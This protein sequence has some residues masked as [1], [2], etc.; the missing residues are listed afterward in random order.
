MYGWQNHHIVTKSTFRLNVPRTLRSL[1]LVRRDAA[2]NLLLLPTDENVAAFL[3]VSKHLGPTLKSYQGGQDNYMLALENTNDFRNITRSSASLGRVFA[4]FVNYLYNSEQALLNGTLHASPNKLID[5]TKNNDLIN[6]SNDIFNTDA[7]KKITSYFSQLEP[8]EEFPGFTPASQIPNLPGFMA[9][10][11]DPQV[12]S[13]PFATPLPALP[14]FTGTPFAMPMLETFPAATPAGPTVLAQNPNTVSGT[15]SG[16]L[17]NFP[18]PTWENIKVATAIFGAGAAAIYFILNPDEAVEAGFAGF[19]IWK[20][21]SAAGAGEAINRGTGSFGDPLLGVNGGYQP[22]MMGADPASVPQLQYDPSGPALPYMLGVNQS[23]SYYDN[24]AFGNMTGPTAP[25]AGIAGEAGASFNGMMYTQPIVDTSPGAGTFGYTLDGMT[26][27]DSTASYFNN[28]GWM[29]APTFG[30]DFSSFGFGNFGFAPIVLDLDGDGV[31]I[32]PLTASNQY[33]DMAGDGYQHRTAWADRGDG[34][35]VLDTQGDGKI[36]ERNEV[37]F[38]DWD[39]SATSDMQ[40]LR[41]IFDTNKNGKLDAGDAKF[42]AFKI[43]VTNADGTTSLKTLAQ[44]GIAS[45]DLTADK[46][47]RVLEDGSSIDGQTTFTRTNGSTGTAAT[48]SFAAEADGGVLKS[49]TTRGSDGSTTIDN[50]VYDAAGHLASETKLLSV[51]FHQTQQVSFDDDGDGVIDDVRTTSHV[52]NSDG[53][54]TDTASD[55]IG[56]ILL[57]KTVTTTSADGRTVTLLRDTDGDGANDQKEVDTTAADGSASVALNDLNE[58]GSTIR[59][60]LRTVSVG[61]QTATTKTDLDGA[62]GYDLIVTD[63]TVVNNDTSRTQTVSETNKDGSLRDRTI[64]TTSADGLTQRQSVDADGDTKIDLFHNTDIVRNGDGSITTTVIEKNGNGSRR[65]VTTTQISGDGLTRNTNYDINGDGVVDAT[66]KETTVVGTTGSRTLYISD[67]SATGTLLDKTV[68]LKEADGISRMT[69]IDADGNGK[70]DSVDQISVDSGVVTEILSNYRPDGTKLKN[71]TVT[72]TSADGLRKTTQYYLDGRYAPGAKPN[73][74]TVVQTVVDQDGVSSVGTVIGGGDDLTVIGQTLV[75]TSANGL[76]V[77]TYVDRDGR[78][79]F[80]LTTQSAT[81][82]GSD[83]VRTTREEVKSSDGT[84]QSSVV[85]VISA[86]HNRTTITSDTNG[87]TYTDS[88]ETITKGADGAVSDVVI[89]YGSGRDGKR[90]S[91]I[92]NKIDDAGLIKVTHTNIDASG[93][94]DEH[95]TD[96]TTLRADG[97]RVETAKTADAAG[98]TRTSTKT[99]VSADGLT[100]VVQTDVNGDDKFDSSTVSDTVLNADG[101]RTTTVTQFAGEPTAT[102]KVVSSQVTTVSD[103][104]LSTTVVSDL[105]GNVLVASS[106]DLTTTDVTTLNADAKGGTSETL[107]HRN[108]TNG[109]VDTSTTT[110][111]ADHK[112]VSISRDLDG[113]TKQDQAETINVQPNGDVV[114][115]TIAYDASGAAIQTVTVTTSADGLWTTR[116]LNVGNDTTI[117]ET[118]TRILAYNLDGSTTETVTDVNAGANIQPGSPGDQSRTET[119]TSANGLSKTI[120]VMGQNEEFDIGHR[121]RDEIVL[122][123]DGGRKETRI[124]DV[125]GIDG[126]RVVWNTQQITDTAHGSKH[127]VQLDAGAVGSFH[128]FDE[129][130]VNNDGGTRRTYIDREGSTL[131]EQEVTTTSA[132]GRHIGI[133]HDTDGDGHNDEF[134]TTDFAV[135]RSRTDVIWTTS[136]AGALLSKTV[137]TTSADGRTMTITFD[138]D[139]DTLV[140]AKQVQVSVVNA[141]GSTTQTRSDYNGKDVLRDRI[142][143]TT[144]ANGYSITGTIDLDGDGTNDETFSNQIVLNA[145]G[146]KTQTIQAKYADGTVKN[147][148]VIQTSANGRHIVTSQDL[149]GDGKG[150]GKNEVVKTDDLA[151]SGV[152]T[153]DVRYYDATG[154]LVSSDTTTTSADGRLSSVSRDFDGNGKPDALELESHMADANGSYD[155]AAQDASSNGVLFE[156]NHLIDENGVDHVY[157]ANRNQNRMTL[158]DPAVNAVAWVKTVHQID[159][160]R[161]RVARIYDVVLDRDPSSAEKETYITYASSNAVASS[162]MYSTEFTQRY[163]TLT[164]AQFVEQMYENAYGRSAKVSELNSWLTKFGAKSASRLDLLASLTSSAEHLTVGNVHTVTSSSQN[165]SGKFSLEH[166]IDKMVAADVVDRIYVTGVGRHETDSSPSSNAS[167]ILAGTQTEAALAAKVVTSSEFAGRYGALTDGQFVTQMFQN[168]LGRAPS[169]TELASWTS[170]L[171]AKTVSRGDLIV[172]LADDLDYKG[173]A[174]ASNASATSS[175]AAASSSSAGQ[176]SSLNKMVQAMSSMSEHPSAAW[177]SGFAGAHA[178]HEPMLAAAHH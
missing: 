53:T 72:T 21:V 114:D 170:L 125:A 36:T 55:A 119:T 168:A 163:G 23:G 100:K 25:L 18:L 32:I 89:R 141:S 161:A 174:T 169:S 158:Y 82:V 131:A 135:D 120:I 103:D 132:D 94:D 59:S 58:D 153:V 176:A 6:E 136:N 20:T 24:T 155:V 26:L 12:L 166:T 51:T 45:I 140:D 41:D 177:S 2:Y 96:T 154:K 150:E 79:G 126:S 144:S 95:Y 98:N 19:A 128:I 64:T 159:Q 122:A 138:T 130:V 156:G 91:I 40:A 15:A 69:S 117:D 70:N 134:K 68:T 109:I 84:L 83:G 43:M 157:T 127:T 147:T 52:T 145:D 7:I 75:T 106:T 105:D 160:G 104:G 1:G 123:A 76:T 167:Q 92:T 56:G 73:V 152:R 99:Q 88:L 57:D 34:V 93:P 3:N 11:T 148:T 108:G 67:Y 118:Q 78:S 133:D 17:Q 139:G 29:P 65:N 46:T 38:T 27:P 9:M 5:P 77:T 49:T 37:V 178:P 33:F 171:G 111:S 97:G 121:T 16:W 81:V 151:S 71:T 8:I 61:G 149:D 110:T 62:G 175:S 48:V 115:A 63:A 165:V 50:K 143:T 47:H 60:T 102:S 137:Q 164:D 87:D 14:G 86:D 124:I 44:A 31:D 66:H 116:T 85:T 129:T 35:L 22:P 39:P 162:V 146:S 54:R 112:Q 173:V 74:K 80:D 101:S 107:T 172:G 10:P 30:S 90:L 113:N 28:G 4:D 142:S 42:A 13:T